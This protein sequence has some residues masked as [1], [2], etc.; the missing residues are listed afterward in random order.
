MI[1]TG[2]VAAEDRDL[3][4]L[5]DLVSPDYVDDRGRDRR[6]LS[7][8][9]HGY[10]IANQSIRLLTRIDR[11]EFPY[12][13][14]ARVDL[15]LGS[16]G[17]EATE[18]SSFDLAADV[19]RLS[20]ELQLDDGEWKVTRAA[21]RCSRAVAWKRRTDVPSAGVVRLRMDMTAQGR[22]LDQHPDRPSR[23]EC[24]VRCSRPCD[25]GE[26]YRAADIDLDEHRLGPVVG[27]GADVP[28][29]SF[30]TLKPVGLCVASMRSRAST[31][32]RT[33]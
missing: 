10:L 13:D 2:E 21:P 17:R 4:A 27:D 3:S 6:E 1:E 31:C 14:M 7:N 8:Y 33:A 23:L 30:L 22:G 18:D 11:I 28:S 19:E 29:I 9:V 25:A 26:Q 12:R 15:T 16:L 24:K 32:S 5:M 20:I